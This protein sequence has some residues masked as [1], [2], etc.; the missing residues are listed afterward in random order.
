VRF[1]NRELSDFALDVLDDYA[2]LE[3]SC[4]VLAVKS[5]TTFPSGP[6]DR[7]TSGS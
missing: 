5:K 6:V 3:A 1:K 4:E 2:T 7:L